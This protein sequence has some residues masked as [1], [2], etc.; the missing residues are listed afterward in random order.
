MAAENRTSWF[1]CLCLFAVLAPASSLAAGK[2]TSGERIKIS[3]DATHAPQKILHA[4]LQIPA[5]PGPLTLYYPKWLPADHSPDGPISNLAGLRFTAQGK[6]IPWQQD[7]V[8]M[9][10]FHLEVPKGAD[11]VD[12]RLDFLLSAPGATIDFSASGSSK[13]LILMWHEVLLY[14]A[15]R[16]ANQI[17]CQPTL[18]LTTGME[19][20][21]F[22]ACCK[23]I[24]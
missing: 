7:D 2:T 16:P 6:E 23:P 14:P 5:S 21:H 8:D 24:R 13:L 3:V 20:Q 1:A 18:A 15:G 10:A 19:I 4:N 9:Y 11:S 12:V 17:V 22:F